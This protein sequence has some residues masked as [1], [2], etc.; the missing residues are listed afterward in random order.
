M[1]KIIDVVR[2]ALEE[3]KGKDIAILDVTNVTDVMD[4]MIVASGSTNRQ[5]KA[6][7]NT[8]IEDAKKAGFQPIGVEGMEGGEWVLVDLG[9]IVIHIMQPAIREFYELE[10]LWSVRPN[11]PV[12]NN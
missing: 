9:D 12:A 1:K 5:V 2:K 4:T 10:K 3:I 6:L 11:D 7:A 8:V